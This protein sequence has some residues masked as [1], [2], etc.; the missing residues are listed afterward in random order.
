M[1]FWLGHMLKR[2]ASQVRWVCVV[3]L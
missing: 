1:Q 3:T 2:H